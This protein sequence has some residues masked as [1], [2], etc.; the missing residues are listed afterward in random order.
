MSYGDAIA[1]YS[2][3]AGDPGTYTGA[4]M[5]GMNY[6]VPWGLLPAVYALSGEDYPKPFSKTKAREPGEAEIREASG[7][8]SP[9]F[10]SLMNK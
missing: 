2:R 3:M 5:A 9:M 6:P 10:R 1:L 4:G 8:M 7:L